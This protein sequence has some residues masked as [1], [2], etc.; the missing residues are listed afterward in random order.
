MSGQNLVTVAQLVRAP[1]C[2]PGGR[3]F[4]SRQ[5][6][7]CRERR[8]RARVSCRRRCARPPAGSARRPT[9]CIRPSGSTRRRRLSIRATVSPMRDE[10]RRGVVQH[11][12]AVVA[13]ALAP[14]S[15]LRA[16]DRGSRSTST[17]SSA[18]SDAQAVGRVERHDDEIARRSRGA[19]PRLRDRARCCARSDEPS[20]GDARVPSTPPISTT[21]RGSASASASVAMFVHGPMP[22]STS[23]PAT[24]LGRRRTGEH[25]DAGEKR[26]ASAARCRD[27]AVDRADADELG[28][29]GAGARTTVRPCR[30]GRRR[31]RCRSTSRIIA[32]SQRRIASSAGSSTGYWKAK[33]D[34]FELG[35]AARAGSRATASRRARRRSG[36]SEGSSGVG[37]HGRAV[38]HVRRARGRSRRS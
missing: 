21:R 8:A 26:R 24:C 19:G 30:R 17:L 25:L 6:P 15:E 1:G 18:W 34:R 13:V 10:H 32:A 35:P 2:G 37:K 31:H 7:S 20:P 29:V 38:Q 22:T 33:P 36:A 27:V 16:E 11:E 23:T 9:R 28:V 14:G 5:S 3:G 4:E 12:R